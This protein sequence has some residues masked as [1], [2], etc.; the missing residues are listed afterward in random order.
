MC[1]RVVGDDGR[2]DGWIEWESPSHDSINRG[3]GCRG[4]GGHKGPTGPSIHHEPVACIN[5]IHVRWCGM[6]AWMDTS[7]DSRRPKNPPNG[8][9]TLLRS[10]RSRPPVCV[11]GCQSINWVSPSAR[12]TNID[13]TSN[14]FNGIGNPM[15][16]GGAIALH[17]DPTPTRSTTR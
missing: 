5:S 7:P 16:M 15:R 13:R 11:L 17:P 9:R 14:Q 8:C 2:L 10:D 4:G 3:D 6:M 12:V 1:V